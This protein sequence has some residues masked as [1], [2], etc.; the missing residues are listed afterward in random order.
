MCE[1]TT[2]EEHGDYDEHDFMGA[3]GLRAWNGGM[4]RALWPSYSHVYA[5]TLVGSNGAALPA[6][7]TSEGRGSASTQS[8]VPTSNSSS[9]SISR[10]NGQSAVFAGSAAAAGLLR[11][12]GSG[13]S[14]SG[15]SGLGLGHLPTYAAG[16]GLPTVYE[17]QQD[18]VH[19][20]VD[21]SQHDSGTAAAAPSGGVAVGPGGT[22][23]PMRGS[24]S[25]AVRRMQ[26]RDIRRSRSSS[27]IGGSLQ[28]R[29]AAQHRVGTAAGA[30]VSMARQWSGGMEARNTGQEGSAMPE[31][32]STANAAAEGGQA[33]CIS[34]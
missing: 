27:G 22:Q 11:L 19:A 34:P 14:S 18:S 4:A 7:F 13:G 23:S 16:A 3:S 5:P 17:V 31:P 8:A 21:V 26:G 2:C 15:P 24:M 28:N 1:S 10:L 30:S 29:Y 25:G 33:Q 20:P 6:V 12:S 9:S 32:S